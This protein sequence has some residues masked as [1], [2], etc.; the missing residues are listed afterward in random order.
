MTEMGGVTI[1]QKPNFKHGSVGHIVKN[2]EMKVI[3]P[4]THK[5][6]GPNQTGEACFKSPFMLSSYY[7]D[8]DATN[9]AVDSE[10]KP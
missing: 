1:Q 4:E 8:P 6:L 7:R 9:K 5:V 10:G 2:I 3:D